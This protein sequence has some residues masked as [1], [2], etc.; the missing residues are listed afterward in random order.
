[1]T[2]IDWSPDGTE[3]ASGAQD[4]KIVFQDG[5]SGKELRTAVLQPELDGE[6]LSVADIAWSPDG[7]MLAAV[8]EDYP[9][10]RYQISSSDNGIIAV[11]NSATGALIKT[12]HS[13]SGWIYRIARSPDGRVLASGDWGGAASLWDPVTGKMISRWGD[14]SLWSIYSIVWS[15]D[16]QTLA[17]GSESGRLALWKPDSA[18]AATVLAGHTRQI[19][20]LAYSPD[21]KTLASG[22]ADGTIILWNTQ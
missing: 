14:G 1:V 11:W 22:S 17:I 9:S 6:T 5:R 4:G 8:M 12:I 2:R 18:D 21:G 15:P 20:S 16:G 7:K 13:D 3:L 19:S 10:A